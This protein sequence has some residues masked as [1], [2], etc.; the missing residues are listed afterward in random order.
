MENSL[1]RQSKKRKAKLS[2]KSR[3]V[4]SE[5]SRKIINKAK[6]IR[7]AKKNKKMSDSELDELERARTPSGM[8]LTGKVQ[9]IRTFSRPLTSS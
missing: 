9:G 7:Q 3:S 6:K 1:E 5:S 2:P 8:E 4:L